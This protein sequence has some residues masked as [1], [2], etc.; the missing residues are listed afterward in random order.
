MLLQAS[1]RSQ[2][3]STGQVEIALHLSVLLLEIEING[4]FFQVGPNATTRTTPRME[5]C[6]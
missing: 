3:E 1:L 4:L 6:G 2:L 5:A